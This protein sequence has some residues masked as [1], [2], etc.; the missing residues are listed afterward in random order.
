MIIEDG[1]VAG[2]VTDKYALRNPLARIM[3]GG[4]LK[5]LRTLVQN[6]GASDL[7]EIGC[8]E[9]HLSLLLAKE[10]FHVR[11]SDFSA[12]VIEKARRNAQA[13]NA[14]IAFQTASIYQLQAP[15]ATAE[16]V[17][18]CE[19]LEHLPDPEH[20]LD[21]LADLARPHL[22][23]SVPREPIWRLLNMARGKYLRHFGN[24]PGHL[25]HWSSR[26]FLH[27]LKRRLEIVECRQPFPWT[28]VH[29]RARG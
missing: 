1:I 21:I 11:A 7:H 20:A 9:G 15:A 24:T 29:C 6:T 27:F 12:Q 13:A 5:S 18:C 26:S 14:N 2:N 8:G 23:V 19:V 16:L 10:G 4:F 28:M 3:V 25:N 17:V 22:I